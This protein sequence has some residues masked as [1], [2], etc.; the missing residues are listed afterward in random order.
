MGISGLMVDAQKKIS[1]MADERDRKEV[2]KIFGWAIALEIVLLV[3][4]AFVGVSFEAFA[5]ANEILDILQDNSPTIMG[6]IILVIIIKLAL[7]L[8]SVGINR[9]VRKYQGVESSGKIAWKFIS[10]TIWLFVA[11]AIVFIFAGNLSEYIIWLAVI[12]AAIIY[13]LATPLQNVA[14]WFLIVMNRPFKIGDIIEMGDMRGYV[15]DVTLSSTVVREMGNW[16][17][18]DLFTGR[19]TTIPNRM[20]FETGASN[21]TRNNK[22]IYDYLAMAITYESD[23]EKAETILLEITNDVLGTSDDDFVRAIHGAETRELIH[24]MPKEPRVFW[25]ATPSGVELGI[26]YLVQM[27][28]RFIIRSEISRRFLKK[29]KEEPDVNVA[30]PHVEVVGDVLSSV[31]EKT[32]LAHE[33]E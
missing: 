21:Y 30:Y 10:Y 23:V 12:I 29:I 3:V 18:G 5:P 15:V 11:I 33:Q 9:I 8:V 26:L 16:V 32:P 1:T 20:I 28:R 6:I 27:N 24:Q 19:F 13:A 2:S 17:H 4:I 31:D 7:D 14:A 22:F 25:N